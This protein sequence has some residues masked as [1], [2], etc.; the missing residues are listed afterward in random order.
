MKFECRNFIADL[1]LVLQRGLKINR[2]KTVYTRF[3]VDVNLDGNSDINLQ[4]Q[5]WERV[6]TFKY[7]GAT[8]AENGDMDAE[9]THRIQSGWKNWKRVSGILCDRRKSLRVKRKVVRPAMMYGAET[10]AVKKAQKKKLDV[11]EM[12]LLRWMSGV[13]KL[14]RIRNESIRGTTMVGGISK[15]VKESRLT[16]YGHVLRRAYEYVSKRVMAMEVPGNR[17]RGR[18]KRRWLD[19]IRHDLSERELSREDA[20]DRAKWR[21]LIRHIDPT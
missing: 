3:N 16:W 20:Q 15:K 8:L 18:P 4:G 19:S 12:R 14:D 21:R 11:A 1:V 13:T 17:R 7:L 10:W 5:N 9:M 6:N 2:K